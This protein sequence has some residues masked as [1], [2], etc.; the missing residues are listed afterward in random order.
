MPRTQPFAMPMVVNTMGL[1]RGRTMRFLSGFAAL[2]QCNNTAC[3]CAVR[4]SFPAAAAG[5]N[6]KMACI[7]CAY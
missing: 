5:V 6:A 1:D 7:A 2:S 3:E 4:S